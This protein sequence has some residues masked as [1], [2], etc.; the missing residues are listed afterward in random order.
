[1]FKTLFQ[2]KELISKESRLKDE[3]EDLIKKRC[4]FVDRIQ[5][6]IL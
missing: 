2:K 5:G 4:D 6:N 3:R 1:M